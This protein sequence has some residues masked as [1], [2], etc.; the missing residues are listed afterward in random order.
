MLEQRAQERWLEQEQELVRKVEETNRKLAE[1]EK[2]K[3]DTQRLIVS[4][5]QEAEIRRFKE[6]RQ[7]INQE[8]KLVRRN[9]RAEIESLG[10]RVKFVN[11]FLMPLF[12]S[13][14]GIGYALYSRR[15]SN[16]S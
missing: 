4:D 13:A 10:S 5:E 2:Q 8:L 1:L 12:V 14:A 15:K 7:R 3:D 11:I 16:Q 9:L 6:E